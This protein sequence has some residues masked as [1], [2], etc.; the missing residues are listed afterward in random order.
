MVD[1]FKELTNTDMPRL[2]PRS[3]LRTVM[4]R[5]LI[6]DASVESRRIT[7]AERI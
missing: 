5:D 3:A 7:Y 1:Q 4:H 2:P 6:S